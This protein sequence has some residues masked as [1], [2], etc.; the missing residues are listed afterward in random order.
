MPFQREV[1]VRRAWAPAP[2][3][4]ATVP[5]EPAIG[6]F[7]SS[8]VINGGRYDV[9]GRHDDGEGFARFDIYDEDGNHINEEFVLELPPDRFM[10]GGLMRRWHARRTVLV[11]PDP[12][13]WHVVWVG[14][15]VKLA[16]ST[17]WWPL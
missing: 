10:V 15:K 9:F 11:L 17:D 8:H 1:A 6:S 5:R 13:G 7:V 3:T 16:L 2:P 4:F 14:E 12:H